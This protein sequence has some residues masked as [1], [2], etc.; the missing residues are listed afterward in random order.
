VSRQ[1]QVVERYIEGFRR[2]DHAQILSSLADDVVWVL[3][4]YKTLHGKDAF[5]AEI[6]NEGF[7]GSPTITIHRL[8]E[9]DDCVVATGTGSVAQ[10]SGDRREF[11]FAEIFT[12]AGDVVNRLDT[13][14]VWLT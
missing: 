3:H 13:Y 4:G 1:K 6:E 2:S 12:F 8:I 7:D 9:E 14:H 11:A 10:K 5:D